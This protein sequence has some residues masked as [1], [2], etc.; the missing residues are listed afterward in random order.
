[1]GAIAFL[2]G[3][4]FVVGRANVRRDGEAPYVGVRGASRVKAAGLEIFYLRGTVERVVEPSTLLRAGD[5]LR[6]VARGERPRFV[7]VRVRDGDNAP[8]VLYPPEGTEPQPI[9]P[10]QTLP[11]VADIGPS[12]GKVTVTALFSDHPRPRGATPDENTDV[13]TLNVVKE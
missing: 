3:L 2:V 8:V 11:V 4:A 10:K 5:R 9:K 7:E 12:P 1:V 6:L 13:V